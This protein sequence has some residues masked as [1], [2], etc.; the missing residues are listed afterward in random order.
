[1]EW[2]TE[3]SVLESSRSIRKEYTHTFD[4]HSIH[5][6]GERRD[7]RMGKHTGHAALAK[8]EGMAKSSDFLVP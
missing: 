8:L 1:M 4:G 5:L 2:G 7:G 3:G 6:K